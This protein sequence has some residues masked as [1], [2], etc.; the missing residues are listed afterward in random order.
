MGTANQVI[1]GAIVLAYPLAE[2]AQ[3]QQRDKRVIMLPVTVEH[4][5][6]L[7]ALPLLHKDPFDRLLIAQANVEVATLLTADATIA[8][9]PTPTLW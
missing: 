9:Y 7:D 1:A 4:I 8:T 2:L 3:I 5:L 6:A